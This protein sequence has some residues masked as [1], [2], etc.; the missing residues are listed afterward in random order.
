[1]LNIYFSERK[2]KKNKKKAVAADSGSEGIFQI[3]DQ[4]NLSETDIEVTF[5]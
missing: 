3:V 4:A 1:M 2:S 5:V